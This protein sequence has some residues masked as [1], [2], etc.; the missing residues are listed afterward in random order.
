MKLIIGLGNPGPSY[1][2]TRHNVG[3]LALD[4]LIDQWGAKGPVEKFDGELFQTTRKNETVFLVKPKTFMNLS[5]K[6]VGSLFKFYQLKPEDLIVIHDDLDLIPMSLRIKH[7]GGTGGHNGLKSLD[8]HLG[9]DQTGYLRIRIGIGHPAS[10]G[11]RISPVD[12]VLEQYK[13]D[14][15]LKLDPLF[16]TVAE[17][18][19]FLLTED[20]S[21]AMTLFNARKEN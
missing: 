18:A 17:A 11:L 10:L 3:F 5:G 15:L 14:E 7:G 21:K 9:K 4:R 20:V 2:T 19:D 12:Y 1:E 16:N 13:N 6:C 8:E